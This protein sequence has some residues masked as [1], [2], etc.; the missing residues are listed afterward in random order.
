MAAAIARAREEGRRLRYDV[1]GSSLGWLVV[2]GATVHGL[3]AR[4][5]ELLPM[6]ALAAQGVAARAGVRG[7][8]F[9]RA[10]M[11]T[12]DLSGS[13][14][15][16]LASQCWDAA[17]LRRVRAKLLRELGEGH[18]PCPATLARPCLLPCAAS[19]PDRSGSSSLSPPTPYTPNTLGRA[20]SGALVLD[21]TALLGELPDDDPDGSVGTAAAAASTL[22][23]ECTVDAPVSWDGTHRFWVWRVTALPGGRSS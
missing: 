13:E 15:V 7:A 18:T 1:L 22:S 3:D 10:D 20:G 12:V 6:L 8:A 19:G 5:V 16:M 21:Y 11:L 17:L 4:G 23:L 2:Y 14:V 9:V